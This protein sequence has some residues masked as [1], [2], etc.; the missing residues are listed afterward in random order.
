MFSLR[1]VFR[2]GCVLIAFIATL[3]PIYLFNLDEDSVQIKFK[4]TYSS[5]DKIYPAMTLCFDRT[6]FH[7]FNQSSEDKLGVDMAHQTFSNQSTLDIEDYIDRIVIK[8]MKNNET[9]AMNQLV[10][11]AEIYI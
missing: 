7:K 4:D 10:K 3:Y 11:K 1:F 9:M 5:E 6:T 2:V 8:D